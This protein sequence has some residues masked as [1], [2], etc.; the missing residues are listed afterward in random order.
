MRMYCNKPFF[1]PTFA[2]VRTVELH[3]AHEL[4]VIT[5]LPFFTASTRAILRVEAESMPIGVQENHAAMEDL[6]HGHGPLMCFF[7]LGIGPYAA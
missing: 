4:Q 1:L 2:P 3:G 7:Y 5:T 6:R